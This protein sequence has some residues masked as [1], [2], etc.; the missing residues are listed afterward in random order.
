MTG[1]GKQVQ[2]DVYQQGAK[3]EDTLPFSFEDWERRAYENLTSGPYHYIADGA[4]SGDTMSE[5]RKAFERWRIVPRMLQ[6]VDA[7]DLSVSVF[8]QTFPAPILFAPIG[9]QS[10]AHPDGEIAATR[11]A[12]DTG[13]PYVASTASSYTMED[14]A[15]VGGNSPRWFQLYW[16]RN[17]EVTASMLQRAEKSGYSAVVVTLDTHVLSWREKDLENTY[18]PFLQA[19]GIANYLSDPAFRAGLEQPP[20]ENIEAA[21]M[22][23]IQNFTNSTL[24]WDDLAFLR[25]HTRL[26]II[27]KGILHPDDARKALDYGVD[28]IIVSNHGGRQVDGAIAALDALPDIAEVVQDSIPVLMDSGI[29]RGADIVKAL[30]LGASAVLVGRP[31]IYGLSVGGEQ[32]AHRVIRNLWADFDLTVALTGKKNISEID[33]SVLKVLK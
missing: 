32:G 23:F 12:A 11:A 6:N 27:L 8:G 21:V 9:V 18:L 13:L 1:Y 14:I 20:E 17:P 24:T 7:R 25:E 19:E 15:E 30:A 4:G 29:R 3:K 26:P 5:N 10:I 33:R 28:G 31:Y 2:F 16:G 22:H